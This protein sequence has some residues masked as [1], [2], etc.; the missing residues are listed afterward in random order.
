MVAR[1]CLHI[2]NFHIEV[3]HI[4]VLHI[5]HFIL[6]TSYEVHI[7]LI[8]IKFA[9]R[10]IQNLRPTSQGEPPLSSTGSTSLNCIEESMKA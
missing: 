10:I 7:N 4:A 9:F 2:E 5:E 1:R 3:F 6:G 8:Y